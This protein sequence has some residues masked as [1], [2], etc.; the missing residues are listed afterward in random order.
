MIKRNEWI[1]NNHKRE[2]KQQGAAFMGITRQENTFVVLVL[3][4]LNPLEKERD[5][6]KVDRAF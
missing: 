5:R 6:Y 2:K 3:R 1:K 4:Q